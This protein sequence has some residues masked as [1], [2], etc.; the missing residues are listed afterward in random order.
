MIEYD[1]SNTYLTKEELRII[2]SA[3]NGLKYSEPLFELIQK[4]FLDYKEYRADEIGQIVPIDDILF[5]TE[6]AAAYKKYIVRVTARTWV[7]FIVST[8]LSIAAII[9][10]I[11]GLLK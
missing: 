8:I 11:I 1:F 3:K 10:S 5:Q 7:P 2:K 9:I 6:K 4:G